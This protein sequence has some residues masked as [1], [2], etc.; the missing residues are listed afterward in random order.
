MDTD[1]PLHRS[2]ILIWI[3]QANQ[4][5]QYDW[6]QKCP[7]IN[8]HDLSNRKSQSQIIISTMKPTLQGVYHEFMKKWSW[9]IFCQPNKQVSHSSGLHFLFCLGPAL[10]LALSVELKTTAPQH[11]TLIWFFERLWSANP[12]HY[13]DHDMWFKNQK[14][15]SI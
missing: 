11:A 8:S 15:K 4:I 9:Y 2:Q 7:L 3:M 13:T 6:N 12:D 10:S 14:N 5:T 1:S